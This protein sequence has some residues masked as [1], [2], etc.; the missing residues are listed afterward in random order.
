MLAPLI[1]VYRWKLLKQTWTFLMKK[2]STIKSRSYVNMNQSIYATGKV[3][4][5]LYKGSLK[6]K[7]KY[8]QQRLQ[9]YLFTKFI[10]K[11]FC[12]V[13]KHGR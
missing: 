6:E 1:F 9:L 4:L 5:N 7:Y 12:S 2:A 13:T 3:T 11:I 8:C 10:V